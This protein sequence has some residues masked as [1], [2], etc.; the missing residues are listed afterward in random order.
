MGAVNFSIDSSLVEFFAERLPI[1]TFVETGTYRGDAIEVVRPYFEKCFSI[2]S[3]EEYCIHAAE[4][5]QNDP[6]VTILKGDSGVAL[7]DVIKEVGEQPILFWLD[8]HWC[9]D[10][11]VDGKTSQCPL[12]RELG[13][14]GR[15]DEQS[16]ILI[17]DARLFLC[18][19]GKPHDYSQWPDLNDLLASLDTL[20]DQ[21][22]LMVIN[23]VIVYYPAML[24][25]DLRRYAHEQGVDW[26][27]VMAQSRD[28]VEEV[29]LRD[30]EIEDLRLIAKERLQIIEEQR[31]FAQIREV[32]SERAN[33]AGPEST[34][35]LRVGG[36]RGDS[37][38]QREI[39]KLRSMIEEQA[40]TIRSLTGQRLGIRGRIRHWLQPRL[41]V[42]YQYPPRTF[43]IPGYYRNASGVQGLSTISIVTPSFNQAEFLELTIKSLVEQNY[44]A[45]EYIIQD[46]GSEDGTVA[47]LK[48]Y[49]N[50]LS[51]WESK[52]DKGQAHAINMGFRHAT[53]EIMAYL[54]SDDLLLPGTLRYVAHYFSENPEV[55]VV[56]GHR[57]L[58]DEKNR[59]VGR[60]V[61]PS[62]DNRVLS[63][64]DYI[65][66]ETLFW[67][68]R[69]WEKAGGNVDESFRFAMDWD[70]ILRFRD[71]GARFVR[72]PR[73]LGAFRVH[74]QQKS[75]KELEDLGHEEMS[76]LRKRCHGRVVSDHDIHKNI[77]I[78]LFK[79]V[80]LNKLYRAK[81]LRY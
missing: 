37:D 80:V 72:L 40:E 73:F 54:N 62:H 49:S 32:G 60:W 25:N 48:K 43:H 70:L 30:R 36:T 56:Y 52:N 34:S 81:I 51:H 67:R 4:R 50:H 39:E 53:G 47:V 19:P 38:E 31:W 23:D 44:P 12:L 33:K 63:W 27:K 58:I 3:S 55:D 15:L 2:E 29:S 16:V 75:S 65:P 7:A 69:M 21:H 74:S 24:K 59:E 41:G 8:A 71:A 6:S 18:P 14:I 17:D 79:H 64:A 22:D 61:L 11:N 45:L 10:E 42:F 13:T 5:F 9:V 78:Y 76:Q 68:R 46:G 20:S 57:V 26:L 77:R 28:L 35:Q 66:Q 1:D